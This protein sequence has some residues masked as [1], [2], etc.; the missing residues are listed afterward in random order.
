MRIERRHTHKQFVEHHAQ[1][2][3]VAARVD[4]D[5]ADLRL[6]GAHI[7]R[8]ADHRAVLGEDRLVRQRPVERL[9]DAE[10]DDLR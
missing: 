7:L 9:G 4:I 1:R 3:D 2:V 8:R 5:S 10:V 6:L